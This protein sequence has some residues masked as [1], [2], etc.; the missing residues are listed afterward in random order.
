MTV[1]DYSALDNP[2]ASARSFHPLRGW[3]E[4]PDGAVDCVVTVA[5][6]TTLS[7][8]FFAVGRANPTVLFFY[9]GGENVAR[10]DDIAPHY[11]R[12]GANFFV[13]DYR[14]FGASSGS[15]SFNAILSDAHEVLDWLQG[16]MQKLRFTGPLYVMG[17][18]MGRHAAGELA[19]TAGD[20]INGVI[21]ESGR[22][23]LGRIAQG[24]AP[25]IVRALEEDYQ[26]KFYSI[27]IPA[28]V[29]HGQWDEAAPLAG[30]V[31]MFNK[32][33]TVHK[34]LEIIPGA[35]HND[36]MYVG[37]QQYF[38]AIRGFMARYAEPRAMIANPSETDLPLLDT[39]PQTV[40]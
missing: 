21:I 28:L 3:T 12:I 27:T 25:E 18:S 24:L 35:S 22:P 33:E 9:G 36:L 23:N 8:R 17:R 2:E 31:D 32:L 26:A 34:R 30:A 38:N 20:R 5:D 19:I 4:T 16:T 7:C 37:F 10:Y 40:T 6:G 11:T 39:G 1:V 13:A 14:G 15:P 29:I